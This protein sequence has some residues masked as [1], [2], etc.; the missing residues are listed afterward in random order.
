MGELA[1]ESQEF[2]ESEKAGFPACP[3]LGRA[4]AAPSSLWDQP[5]G[6]PLLV[7]VE[8]RLLESV[9]LWPGLEEGV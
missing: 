9:W 2:R 4:A 1:A 3:E 8:T 5:L 6:L 7:G